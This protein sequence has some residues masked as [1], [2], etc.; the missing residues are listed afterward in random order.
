[1]LAFGN[2]KA[3]ADSIINSAIK[4]LSALRYTP[5]VLADNNISN[6]QVGEVSSLPEGTVS[7][8]CKFSCEW[9]TC[10]EVKKAWMAWK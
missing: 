7:L 10:L 1:M 9:C 4:N 8:L 6:E 5:D 3:F 2:T